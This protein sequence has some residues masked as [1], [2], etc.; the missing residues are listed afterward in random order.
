MSVQTNTPVIALVGATATGKTRLA[1]GLAH[2]L[3]GEVV[4]ADSMQFYKGMDI[5]T[6]KAPLA[7][8]D[9]IV[10]HLLDIYDLSMEASV[11][12]FQRLARDK[13]REIRSRAKTPILTGGSGLYVRAALDILEFP[14]TDDDLR[15]RLTSQ[16]NQFGVAHLAAELRAVDP[17]AARR[18]KDD[19]RII[20]AVEVYRL[21]GRPFSSYM[22]RR[23]YDPDMTPVV[24]IGLRIDRARLH[25]RI[26]QRVAAMV[27]TGWVAEVEKLLAAGLA[28]APTASR[29]IGYRQMMG[30][31]AGA[32]TQQAAIDSTIVATR[33]FARRQETWFKADPR[34][35]WIDA[36]DSDLKTQ[37]LEIIES[38]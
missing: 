7:E 12:E 35:H 2:A 22:P 19:R 17:D 37:A 25:E 32:T 14:P 1:V 18:L 5:G 3:D 4:N 16:V 34:V 33:R 21:T 11:A 29:A 24:Q 36:E 10:H 6:A 8:R 27:E 20:R 9:G 13:I 30:Y 23:Q 26:E 38:S 15:E 28:D 31:L